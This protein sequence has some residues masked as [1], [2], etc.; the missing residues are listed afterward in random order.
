MSKH[1]LSGIDFTNGRRVNQSFDLSDNPIY[2]NAFKKNSN[3]EKV[4]LRK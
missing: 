3:K 1:T 4:K 2:G